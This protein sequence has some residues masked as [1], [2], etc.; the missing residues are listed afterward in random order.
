MKGETTTS[1]K[2]RKQRKSGNKQDSSMTEPDKTRQKS[3]LIQKQYNAIDA[4]LD[5][6]TDQEAAKRCGVSRQTVNGWKNND[7]E[8]IEV[9]NRRREELWDTH[10]D[11]L[12]AM[13]GIAVQTLADDLASN[14]GLQIKREA[15]IH[16]LKA[17]GLYGKDARP[18]PSIRAGP[19]P[20][21]SSPSDSKEDIP[22]AKAEPA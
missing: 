18:K 22:R 5:G 19:L 10:L 6:A 7:P 20:E 14:Y 11:Q 15:A 17:I 12:R 13:V 2:K 9:L 8:F 3:G 16:V 4:I 21:L 1:R